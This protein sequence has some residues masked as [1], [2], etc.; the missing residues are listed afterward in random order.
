MGFSALVEPPV[1]VE[2]PTRPRPPKPKPDWPFLSLVPPE[3]RSLA[4][5]RSL[6]LG[7][8]LALHSV[9]LAAVILVPILAS[10]TLPATA[11]DT[12][13]AFLVEPAVVLPPPPPPPPPA[14]A[15]SALP[16]A[17]AQPA[18]APRDAK[19]IAPIEVP[20]RI[21]PE[22]ET[23]DLGAE[24][25]VPGGVE[26]GVP[27]GVVGGV[28]GGLPQSTSPTA[29]PPVVRV[30]GNVAAPKLI[31]EVR[32]AYPELAV[33]ARVSAI[34]VLEARV[35]TQG[36]VRAAEVLVGN[37]LFDEAAVSALMQWRY[38]PL[39]LNGIPTKFII[40]VTMIFRVEPIGR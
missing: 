6:T 12:L 33:M 17:V 18:P 16:K 10:D 7:V 26:G 15:L 34:V 19:L 36:Y 25:G 11:R 1:K 3:G 22:S 31:R 27:G 39:L 4:K 5:T 28:V 21:M 30:G 2:P 8:S 13:R 29:P 24:A 40:N 23:F 35:D 9:L 32:P 38:Q 20:E 37:K 14:G